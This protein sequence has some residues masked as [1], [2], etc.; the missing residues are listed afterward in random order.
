M[1]HTGVAMRAL[2]RSSV[3]LRQVLVRRRCRWPRRAVHAAWH[4]ACALA[5]A[6]CRCAWPHTM[7]CVLHGMLRAPAALCSMACDPAAAAGPTRQAA[8][9]GASSLAPGPTVPRA[10][11]AAGRCA[12]ASLS[13]ALDRDGASQRH[14]AAAAAGCTR[15]DCASVGPGAAC[16]ASHAA[17]PLPARHRAALP[18]APCADGQPEQGLGVYCVPWISWQA[19]SRCPATTCTPP[20]ST[21]RRAPQLLKLP[22]AG[23]YW[24]SATASSSCGGC[25]E[26]GGSSSSTW[27][28]RCTADCC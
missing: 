25:S 17:Q 20:C 27:P 22:A 4:A 23:H 19:W 11:P 2:Q 24:G 26:S 15:A 28:S 6:L 18:G 14:Y 5:A 10:G 3:F 8:R 12:R 21:S 16:R 13:R 7:L 1:R 9:A